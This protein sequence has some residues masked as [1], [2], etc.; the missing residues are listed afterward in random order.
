MPVRNFLSLSLILSVY[1]RP[2]RYIIMY[3]GL[4]PAGDI[5]GYEQFTSS[6]PIG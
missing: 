3:I 1:S 5:S 6:H 4:S 2:T